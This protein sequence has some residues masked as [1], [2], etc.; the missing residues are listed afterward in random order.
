MLPTNI[1][2]QSCMNAVSTFI[3]EVITSHAKGMVKENAAQCRA[4]IEVVSPFVASPQQFRLAGPRLVD[5]VLASTARGKIA[6][7]CIVLDGLVP[8][9]AKGA[10]GQSQVETL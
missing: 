6:V 3:C 7:R 1:R 2:K 4:W 9:V 5:S 10:D 8:L